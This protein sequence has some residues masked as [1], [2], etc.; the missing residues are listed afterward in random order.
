MIPIRSLVLC[1]AVL[2]ALAAVEFGLS[3]APIGRD[4]RTVLLAFPVIM[5]T[6]IAMVFMRLPSAPSIARGFAFAGLVWLTIL[7]GLASMDPLTRHFYP[8]GA[9]TSL[10]K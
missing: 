3:F 8:V 5:A 2:L 9:Q 4:W 6:I 1:W 7:I 10:N